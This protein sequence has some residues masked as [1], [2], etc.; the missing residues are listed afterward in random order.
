MRS[1]ISKHVNQPIESGEQMISEFS[2]YRYVGSFYLLTLHYAL[3]ILDMYVQ[4]DPFKMSQ[5]SGVAPCKTR[6]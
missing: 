2:P 4:G 6:F 1:V 3:K 5:T